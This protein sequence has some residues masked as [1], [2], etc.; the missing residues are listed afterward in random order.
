MGFELLY[1]HWLVLGAA[2]MLSEIYFR[3]F[4]IV[5]FGAGALSVGF[6]VL[7]LSNM[8]GVAQIIVWAFSSTAYAVGW[9]KF[10]KPLSIDDTQLAPSRKS[11]VGEIGQVLDSPNGEKHGKLRFPTA[12][13]GADEWLILSEDK[14]AVGDR[15]SV[16]DLTDNALVVKK[17]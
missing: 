12:V 1:W 13:L 5:W 11:L 3:S 16:I 14:L 10:V 9:F 7:V 4:V 15:V 17:T 2:L 8:S 6:S